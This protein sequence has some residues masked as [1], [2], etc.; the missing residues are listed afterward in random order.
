MLTLMQPTEECLVFRLQVIHTVS[1]GPWPWCKMILRISD[2]NGFA[3]FS[4]NKLHYIDSTPCRYTCDKTRQHLWVLFY[5]RNFGALA[6]ATGGREFR[7]YARSSKN[8][9]K[10]PEKSDADQV[11]TF[12]DGSVTHKNNVTNTSIY[13][14]PF[15]N[16]HAR[17]P[18]D[19]INAQC[20]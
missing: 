9:K 2:S 4:V 15:Q 16:T 7:L 8:R 14:K 19:N 3:I 10:N 20:T 18:H 6:I 5:T 12:S 17:I 1:S 11:W 13:S